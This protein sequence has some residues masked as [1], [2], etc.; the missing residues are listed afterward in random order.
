MAKRTFIYIDDVV[1]AIIN[2]LNLK[3]SEIINIVGNESITVKGL[4]E[5]ICSI[6]GENISINY[7]NSDIPNQ[8]CL[9][10]NSKMRQLLL[11]QLTP[12]KRGLEKEYRYMEGL[13]KK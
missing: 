12:L 11:S 8:D 4:A 9:F 2:S 1:Q 13:L 3:Q 10:D 6:S 5:L 7:I